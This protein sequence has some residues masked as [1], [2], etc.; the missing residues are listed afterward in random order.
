MY[1][2]LCP[3]VSLDLICKDLFISLDTDVYLNMVHK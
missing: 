1:A 3:Y 2:R